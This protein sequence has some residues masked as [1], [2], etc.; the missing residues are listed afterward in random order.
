MSLLFQFHKLKEP[1][2]LYRFNSYPV[3]LLLTGYSHLC[4]LLHNLL[5]AR[6]HSTAIGVLYLCV[7]YALC[8]YTVSFDL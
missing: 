2:S 5:F 7:P 8:F 1:K 3:L 6:L 4:C